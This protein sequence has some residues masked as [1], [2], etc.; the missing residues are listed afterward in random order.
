MISSSQGYTTCKLIR[1]RKT[2]KKIKIKKEKKKGKYKWTKRSNLHKWPKYNSNYNKLTGWEEKCEHKK[3]KTLIWV[4]TC[5]MPQ[6]IQSK[7]I[8]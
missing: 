7:K 8:C 1:R 3:L 5:Q 4:A 2:K 6:C